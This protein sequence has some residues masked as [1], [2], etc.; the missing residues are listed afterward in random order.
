M[1]F[2][3]NDDPLADNFRS[4]GW[5]QAGRESGRIFFLL[6]LLVLFDF[7]VNGRKDTGEGEIEKKLCVFWNQLKYNRFNLSFEWRSKKKKNRN[8]IFHS[9]SFPLGGHTLCRF[10]WL[11]TDAVWVS[12]HSWWWVWNWENWG[13]GWT[14]E[15]WCRYGLRIVSFSFFIYTFVIFVFIMESF[16]LFFSL[17]V[18]VHSKRR[19]N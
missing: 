7:I 15:W 9:E 1:K 13:G 19:E 17:L 5:M 4:S 12:V 3:D 16:F 6:H 10:W 8:F 2:K 14:T 18:S 11:I